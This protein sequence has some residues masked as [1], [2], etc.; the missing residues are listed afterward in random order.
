[1]DLIVTYAL[2]LTKKMYRVLVAVGAGVSTGPGLAMS[3]LSEFAWCTQYDGAHTQAL[4]GLRST[5]EVSH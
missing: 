3:R 1:M 5:A 4:T 2:Q